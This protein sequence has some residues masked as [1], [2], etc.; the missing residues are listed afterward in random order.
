L[1]VLL[2]ILPARALAQAGGPVVLDG[3]FSDWQGQAY[4]T[5]PRNDALNRWTDIRY[6]YFATNPD[7]EV[8]YF[9]LERWQ[10]RL[11]AVDYVLL[12]DT[13]NNGVYTDP[14]DRR[15]AVH[16][17]PI[18]NGYTDVALY[19]GAGGF[20][21]TIAQ[22]ARWGESGAGA[23]VEFGA[24]FA[25]LGIAP[26]QTIRIQARSMQGG[27]VSDTTLEVQWSPADALGWGLSA[28]LALLAA[29]WFSRKRK[30]LAWQ[31]PS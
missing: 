12:V 18:P 9:M 22:D 5:D 21:R 23:R 19:N 28:G 8:A 13:N 3:Q 20:I 1:A 7:E 25:D 24:S 26:Y 17:T 30:K 4:I 27:S 16:Y 11:L 10:A 6:L 31:P 29:V 2:A 14:G 15:I